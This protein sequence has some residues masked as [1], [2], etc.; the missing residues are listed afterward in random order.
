[1]TRRKM[2]ATTGGL[3]MVL[4]LEFIQMIEK[5]RS[6]GKTGSKMALSLVSIKTAK[7]NQR[8]ITRTVNE[9]ALRLCGM[10]K[11]KS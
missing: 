5:S 7:R 9:M 1:M 11:A 6:I 2:G 8:A 4:R 3:R 10:K